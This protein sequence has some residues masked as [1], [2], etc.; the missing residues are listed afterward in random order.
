MNPAQRLGR[1]VTR[2]HP[3]IWSGAVYVCGTGMIVKVK[4]KVCG[5]V[6]GIGFGISIGTGIGIGNG[7]GY[8]ICIA[9][10]IA[11]GI[12]ATI[13]IIG[14]GSAHTTP[15]FHPLG[16]GPCTTMPNP[17]R[18]GSVND[19]ANDNAN[20]NNHNDCLPSPNTDPVNFRRW[21]VP[22]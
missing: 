10:A 18:D 15:H 5:W 14:T 19:H 9:I 16:F 22:R 3:P 12:T 7:I 11:I 13:C 2:W 6:C 21:R 20:E 8:G 17:N 4:V 1:T